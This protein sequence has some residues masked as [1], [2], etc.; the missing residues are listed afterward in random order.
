MG[1][2]ITEAEEKDIADFMLLSDTALELLKDMREELWR[3]IVDGDVCNNE[4]ILS[5]HEK[6]EEFITRLEMAKD[7]VEV[8]ALWN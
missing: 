2:Y 8:I 3:K 5:N 7:R 1:L 4:A 6:I